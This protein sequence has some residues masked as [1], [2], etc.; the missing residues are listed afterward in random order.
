MESQ[1]ME[2]I[3]LILAA[4]A[5]GAVAAAKDTAGTAVKDAYESLKALIKK[6]FGSSVCLMQQTG[7]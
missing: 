7:L 5:A 6:K 1:A 3:S 4:L 2:P